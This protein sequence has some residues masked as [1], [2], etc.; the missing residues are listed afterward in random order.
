MSKEEA[1]S[2]CKSKNLG[3]LECSAKTGD[4]VTQAFHSVAEK[5]TKIYPKEDKKNDRNPIIDEISKKKKEFQLQSAADSKQKNN[6]C[7]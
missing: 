3:F 1:E 6:T 4:N 7:C 5:L 2:Y